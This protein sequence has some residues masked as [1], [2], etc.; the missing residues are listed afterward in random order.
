[1]TL[2]KI[3]VSTFDDTTGGDSW[4]L[5]VDANDGNCS[6]EDGD[7]PASTTGTIFSIVASSRSSGLGR[8]WTKKTETKLFE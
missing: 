2:E 1:M 7:R 8:F 6:V 5:L 3:D 4:V